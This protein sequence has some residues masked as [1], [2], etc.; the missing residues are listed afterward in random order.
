MG[1]DSQSNLDQVAQSMILSDPQDGSSGKGVD[2]PGRT[3]KPSS[4]APA[5]QSDGVLDQSD[6]RQGEDTP[7]ENERAPIQRDPGDEDD[8]ETS[9]NTIMDDAD[10]SDD[11][12]SDEGS[13]SDED[14]EGDRSEDYDPLDDALAADHERDADTD[15]KGEIDASKLGDDTKLSVTVDGEDQIVTLGDLKRRYAGEGAIEKR[16]QAATEARTRAFEDYE[17]GRQLTQQVLEGFGSLMFR[18]TVEAPSDELLNSNPAA[19]TRQKALYDRETEALQQAQGQLYQLTTQ[20]DQ[21]FEQQKQAHRQQAAQKL[22]EIMPVFN[23]PVKGPKV[24]DALVSAAKEIGYTDEQ[25]AACDD[26][27]MFKTV[28][29]AARELRRLK[30]TKV[31]P[32]KTVSRTMTKKAAPKVSSDKRRQDAAFAKAR[33]T[34]KVDDVAETMIIQ[35][36]R[37]K[38]TMA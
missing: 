17:R 12:D 5:G 29:L 24:R 38:R 30:G 14:D 6:D 35:A 37:K 31:V 2:V 9:Q 19:Y 8:G 11:D 20:L 15:D 22:R 27:L 34:G 26:P 7:P 13:S 10:T 25:I 32:N 18:R 23:D 16:L 21:V 28:A 3:S 1:L 36:P 4:A 33:K